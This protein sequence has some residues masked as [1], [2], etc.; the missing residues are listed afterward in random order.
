MTLRIVP[1][2]A[3]AHGGYARLIL[4]AAALPDAEVT[5]SVLNAYNKKFLGA[6][7]FQAEP[8]AFGPYRVERDGGDAL[9][10]IGPEI[11]NQIEEYSSLRITVGGHSESVSWPDSVAPAFGAA[12]IGG[13]TVPGGAPATA[14][15]NLVG[16]M[17]EPQQPEHAARFEPVAETAPQ[18]GADPGAGAAVPPPASRRPLYAVAA[19]AVVG[20]GLGAL[21]GLGMFDAEPIAPPP[22]PLPIAS[23]SCDAAALGGLR[24]QPFP[25]VERRLRDCGADAD[26]DAALALLEDGA[27]ASDPTALLIFGKMYDEAVREAE[28]ETAMGLSFADTP[29]SA[30]EYYAKAGDAGSVEAA[31][32]LIGACA[33][34][35]EADDTRSRSAHQDYCESQ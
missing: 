24:G 8:A 30:A 26:P 23:G 34:L 32:L 7:G 2:P 22:P 20:L 10:T 25:E 35:G 17:P 21:Y 5:V 18:Q 3:R 4:P 12:K 9:V 19:L 28:F 15:S 16:R 27:A 14:A 13:V 33:R 31:G 1:D 11:V 6:D 29:A